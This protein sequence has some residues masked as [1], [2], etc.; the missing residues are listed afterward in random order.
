M[1]GVSGSSFP[2]NRPR[3]FACNIE[4][5]A[6]VAFDLVD[7]ATGKL[8]HQIVGEFH[9]IGGHTVLGFDRS[10]RDC[11]IVSALVAHYADA[12]HRQENSEALP[13]FIIPTAVFHLL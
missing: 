9:P 5:D 11:V 1:L 6:I 8:L 13:D 3:G 2:L 10:N 7:Y 4:A 12:P